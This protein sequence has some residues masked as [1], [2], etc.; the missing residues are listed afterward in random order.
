MQHGRATI[1][2]GVLVLTTFLT[3]GT[4]AA[5]AAPGARSTYGASPVRSATSVAK[6]A[7]D[8]TV[9]TQTSTVNGKS[10]TILVNSQGLP[11]YY[12]SADTAKKSFV[13]GELAGFW[14][15]L[16]SAKPTSSAIQGKLGA[17][18]VP[19]GDQ[20][21]Y[22]GHFLYTFVQDSPGRVTG[23]GVSNFF[24]ATPQLKAIGSH[25]KVAPAKSTSSA[26]RYGY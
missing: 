18:K 9:H 23:Q 7:R 22:N 15:P 2:G 14:P 24:V 5:G 16:I 6:P 3:V 11:L 8:F 12:F 17:L 4:G 10:E 26:S 19:A 1:L 21:T 25:S 20:V 13:S